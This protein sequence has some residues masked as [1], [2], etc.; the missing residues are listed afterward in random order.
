MRKIV[1]ALRARTRNE[2]GEPGLFVVLFFVILCIALTASL[3]WWADYETALER[4]QKGADNTA[5]SLGLE[6]TMYTDS[7]GVESQFISLSLAREGAKEFWALQRSAVA[8][9]WLKMPL[10]D[11]DALSEVTVECVEPGPPS[12]PDLCGKLRV[13]VSEDFTGSLLNPIGMTSPTITREAF[14]SLA[15]NS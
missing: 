8:D 4:M 1:N 3:K 14:V 9:N 5:L 11:L 13:V 15:D 10:L 2:K 12:N 7:E 6:A